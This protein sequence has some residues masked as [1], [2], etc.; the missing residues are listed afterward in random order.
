MTAVN[1]LVLNESKSEETS[2]SSNQASESTSARRWLDEN[3]SL[4]FDTVLAATDDDEDEDVIHDMNGRSASEVISNV[5]E[6][7][8]GVYKEEDHLCQVNQAS[9]NL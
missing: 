5:S 4:G 2:E 1:D 3:W 7:C 9:S 8:L 6:R